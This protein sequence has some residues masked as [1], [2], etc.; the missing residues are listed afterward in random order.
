MTLTASAEVL[1]RREPVRRGLAG[2]EDE[3]LSV[4]RRM[5]VCTFRMSIVGLG[6]RA[7]KNKDSTRILLSGGLR[8]DVFRSFV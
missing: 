1:P 7:E 8:W 5:E 2:R 6:W 3:R 4:N